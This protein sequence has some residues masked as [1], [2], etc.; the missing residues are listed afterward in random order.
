MKTINNFCR[1]IDHLQFFV[2]KGHL[3]RSQALEILVQDSNKPAVKPH[4][5]SESLWASFNYEY[6]MNL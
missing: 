2:A 1:R 6:S 3:P 5:V 4:M